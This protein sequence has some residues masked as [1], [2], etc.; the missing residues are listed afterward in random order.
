M[1]SISTSQHI[2]SLLLGLALLLAGSPMACVLPAPSTLSIVSPTPQLPPTAENQPPEEV[3]SV[4]EI[5]DEEEWNIVETFTGKGN[6]TTA[7]FYISGTE[8]R[9]AWAIDAVYP[10]HA[11]FQLLVHPEGENSIPAARILHSGDSPT[12]TTHIYEGERSYYLKIITANLHGWTITIEDHASKAASS[13]IQITRI[14]YKGRDYFESQEI[15]YEI[16]EADEYVEIANRVDYE[17]LIGGWTLRNISRGCPSF[18]F[19]AHRPCPCA[20]YSNQQACLDNCFPPSPC[21]LLPHHSIRV[22]TGEIYNKSDDFYDKYRDSGGFA[23]NYSPGD[24]WDNESPDTA[25]LYNPGGEEVSR[26]S[27]I[28]PST[29]E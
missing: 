29:S 22:Y 13:P 27:Y 3:P 26:R 6:K 21:V 11:V 9:I 15:G 4:Q 12:N 1:Y 18:T 20:W 8:W 7:P 10:E 2:S 24:I 28:I 14:N 17:Q 16:V 5:L 25:A 23:F 19:P